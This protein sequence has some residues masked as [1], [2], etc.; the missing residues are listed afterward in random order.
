MIK[1]YVD[2]RKL[3]N[4]VRMQ[5][6]LWRNRISTSD[7][8]GLESRFKSILMIDLF[9]VSVSSAWSFRIFW[10]LMCPSSMQTFRLWVV[11]SQPMPSF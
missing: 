3:A 2:S 8:A 10:L 1:C 6:D 7:V 4:R 5:K 11:V 9:N